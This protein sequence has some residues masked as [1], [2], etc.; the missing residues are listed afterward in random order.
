L[1]CRLPWDEDDEDEDDGS[2]WV[3]QHLE[4]RFDIDRSFA[5]NRFLKIEY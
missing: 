1:L 5:E 4:N 2:D 3:E